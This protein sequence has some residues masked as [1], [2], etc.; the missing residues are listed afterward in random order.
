MYLDLTEYKG[1]QI[2]HEHPRGKK[3]AMPYGHTVLPQAVRD[4]YGGPFFEQNPVKK[5]FFSVFTPCVRTKTG[6]TSA[7]Y[8]GTPRHRNRVNLDVH[9]LSL[10]K[11]FKQKEASYGREE[12]SSS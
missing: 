7:Q 11:T 4:R 10:E 9:T 2:I 1:A 3:E 5:H 8:L 6:Y 12:E